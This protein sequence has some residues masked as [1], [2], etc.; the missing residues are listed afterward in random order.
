MKKLVA[1]LL[2]FFLSAAQMVAQPVRNEILLP[3][4]DGFEVLKC[5][6]HMHTVFSDGTVWPAVRVG[7]AW[8]EGLD[9]IAITD[10]LEYLPHRNYVTPSP[11]APWEIAQKSAAA[12]GIILIRGTEITKGMP[13]GHFN[14]L[15]VKDEAKI[16]N[17]DYVASLR[18]A[19]AQGAF[20]LWNHPGWKSQAPDGAIWMP[21]HEAL[22]REGL[23]SGIE[24]VNHNEWYPEVLGWALERDLTILANSD[25]HD[26]VMNYL[27]LEKMERRPITLVFARERSEQGIR[28]ALDERR[29]VAW[30]RNMMMGEAR[31]LGQLFK[32][33]V[34]QRI[35]TSGEK[36]IVLQLTNHSDLEFELSP[37]KET[38]KI[39]QLP[40]RS[41]VIL[42]VPAVKEGTPYLLNN[43][44][45]G[46]TKNLEISLPL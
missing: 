17:D 27:H 15:F 13:P 5:D 29:T 11:S 2:L 46:P 9:A 7:E 23:F 42:Q 18:E 33:A 24:V 31:W 12:T 28:E 10:H 44:Y 19:K 20:V 34:T 45:T 22:F 4:T 30:F 43:L 16:L 40:P 32:G 38:R 21:E 39:S 25:V 35:I 37:A 3:V 8:Q 1:F 14:A 6:F 26:P 41:S 36:N